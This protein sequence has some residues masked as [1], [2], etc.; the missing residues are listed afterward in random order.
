VTKDEFK[1]FV[2]R[3]IADV[4]MGELRRTWQEKIDTIADQWENDTSESFQRGVEAGY[5]SVVEPSLP[6][7]LP[8]GVYREGMD[9]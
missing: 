9:L 4:P 5:E 6:H 1:E 7:G 8:Q 2:T 3:M